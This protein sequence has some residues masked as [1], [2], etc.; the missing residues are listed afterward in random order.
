M[1]IWVRG[2]LEWESVDD[3]VKCKDQ[4]KCEQRRR[5]VFEWYVSCALTMTNSWDGVLAIEI[6]VVCVDVGCLM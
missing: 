1:N 3:V 2:K 5:V 4:R 6:K